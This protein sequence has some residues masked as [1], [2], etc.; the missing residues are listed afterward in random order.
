MKYFFFF[1]LI[2]TKSTFS[3][4][5]DSIFIS[6]KE[7]LKIS[8]EINKI[9]KNNSLYVD[10]LNWNYINVEI[11]NITANV[12]TREDLKS[13]YSFYLR[14]LRKAGDFHSNIYTQELIKN[15][16]SKPQSSKIIAKQ[17][18]G[19]YLG[20]GIGYIKV[21]A[22]LFFD[23]EKNR[24]FTK[25]IQSTIK[26]IDEENTIKSWVVDLRENDGGDASPMLAGLNCLIEDGIVAYGISPFHKREVVWSSLNGKIKSGKTNYKFDNYKVRTINSKFAILID[27]VTASSGEIAAISFS[28]L[29]N[30]KLFGQPSAGY[31]SSNSTVLIS[32]GDMILIADSYVADRN[33][34]KY[35]QK[36][37]PD[38]ITNLT[39][40]KT[41][42]TLEKAINWLLDKK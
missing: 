18:S 37:I 6:Q 25:Q 26:K 32:N 12:K 1:F 27:S 36:I 29:E 28:G 9:I 2:L 17:V 5:A 31:T 23:A 42:D 34:K 16:Q 13:V 33:H 7:A 41:D 21:P 14:Q 24:E 11:Q 30:A 22:C 40:S 4:K 19:K 3:Q 35:T 8:N 39:N 20:D 10:S 15:F 38:I